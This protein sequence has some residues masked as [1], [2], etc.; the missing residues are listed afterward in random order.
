[1][2]RLRQIIAERLHGLYSDR[3]LK[4]LTIELCRS[5]PGV[6]ENDFYRDT[7]LQPSSEREDLLNDWLERLASGEPLQYVIGCTEFCGCRIHCD[8][9]ALIPRPETSELV[10]W[11]AEENGND[12]VPETSRKLIDIGT[13]TGCIAIALARKLQGWNI[14][15]WDISNDALSLA[16][17]N[18]RENGV[19]VH[20]EQRDVMKA[21]N[22]GFPCLDDVGER[23]LY[24]VRVIVS[25]PPYIAEREKV[26]MES[27]VLDYEPHLA[28][29]VPDEDPLR[30]YRAIA[31]L[32]TG[33]LDN[34]GALYFE[35]N[36]LYA[37]EMVE[38]LGGMG[39]S[40]TLRYDIQGR[41]R[42]LKA[43][44]IL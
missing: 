23:N 35:I 12:A 6:R 19:T 43:Q 22:G 15:A 17:G 20:L 31:E 38:M 29:F 41:K 36:P 26:A 40:S 10:E 32:G 7:V 21:A 16:A 11:V 14:S 1:M 8:Y 18:C 28:L 42:M 34:D 3:E 24:P 13:G 9:R 27:N 39:Y 5:L 30:F 37:D 33:C 25:N 44:K 4:A 2:R